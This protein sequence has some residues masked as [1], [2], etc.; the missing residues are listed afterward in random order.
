M[1]CLYLMLNSLQVS[2]QAAE[3]VSVRRLL[4]LPVRRQRM[5]QNSLVRLKKKSTMKTQSG[6]KHTVFYAVLGVDSQ[7]NEIL[8]GE[9]FRGESE[10]RA[11]IR[12]ITRELGLPAL[13]ED[14]DRN[15]DDN[16]FGVLN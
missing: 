14:D 7:G 10:S 8:L 15:A 3:I 4:G 13:Q 9:G 6:G 11:A 16:A 1:G 5:H 12:M 2:K